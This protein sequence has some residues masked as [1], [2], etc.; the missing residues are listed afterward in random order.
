MLL[1][2][3]VPYGEFKCIDSLSLFFFESKANLQVRKLC[4]EAFVNLMVDVAGVVG[5]VY[6]SEAE[7]D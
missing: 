3:M 6:V 2:S 4:K 5:L 1:L 7:N